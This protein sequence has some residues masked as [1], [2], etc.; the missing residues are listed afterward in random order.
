ME[1][2]HCTQPCSLLP[3][4][5]RPLP[6]AQYLVSPA[7]PKPSSASRSSCSTRYRRWDSNA[8]NVRSRKFDF[9]FRG[10]NETDDDEEEEKVDDFGKKRRWWSD[11]SPGMEQETSGF[12]EE[13]VDSLWIFEVFR[14]FG[15]TL[16]VILLSWLL[17]NGPNAFLLALVLPLGQ[18]ALQLAFEKLWGNAESKPKPKP[19]MRRKR[20]TRAA[21]G[22]QEEQEVTPK[23]RGGKA[24]YQS[25][26]N[27]N[28]GS[29]NRGN[30]DASGFGGWE[31]L[32]RSGPA[33]GTSRVMDGAQ[34][35]PM[36]EGKLS[37]RERKRDTPLFL[38]LLIALFPFLGSWTKML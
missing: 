7:N 36:E 32:D 21:T 18:S 15:W 14:S 35:T 26:M 19:R 6:P 9:N 5:C 28:N 2:H 33:T 30:R 8:E 24:S 10:R 34:R 12:W 1:T 11:E 13:A 29:V 37:R 4:P 17:F 20:S 27:E 3:Q 23:A 31:D 16:P 25:W 22:K 38:R